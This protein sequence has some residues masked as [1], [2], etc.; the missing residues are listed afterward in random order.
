MK[1]YISVL[2]FLVLLG[3]DAVASAQGTQSS[4]DWKRLA[5][6]SVK[7]LS[8]AKDLNQ[9]AKPRVQ[10]LDEAQASLELAQTA[11]G[12]SDQLSAASDLVLIY[13]QITLSTDRDAVRAFV[14]ERLEGY[15]RSLD[16][17]VETVNLALA[18]I[19]SAG[20]AAT[21]TQLR[22]ELRNGQNLLRSIVI[23]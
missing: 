13:A 23:K 10:D 3:S 21:G 12:A 17:T 7:Y 9:M 11:V 18:R 4:P 19:K 22:E 1:S 16:L 2:L 14:S 5:D 8:Y 20:I 15:S 6:Q